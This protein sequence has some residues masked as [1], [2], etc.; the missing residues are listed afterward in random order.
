MYVHCIIGNATRECYNNGTWG[1][2][3]VLS[4]QT[5]AMFLVAE[6]VC[7]SADIT[8]QIC[9]YTS[10]RSLVIQGQGCSARCH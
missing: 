4:C 9:S 10:P 3:S 5:L 7:L 1:D 2:A 6:E 8:P